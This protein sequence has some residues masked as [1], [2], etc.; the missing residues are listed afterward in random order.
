MCLHLNVISDFRNRRTM[1]YYN[2]DGIQ[3]INGMKII[4]CQSSELKTIL[5][6]NITYSLLYSIFE[7]AYNSNNPVN[8]WYNE[9]IV[10]KIEG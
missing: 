3:S 6:R 2:S 7:Q 9:E 4:S 5:S 1:E 8:R 10:Q